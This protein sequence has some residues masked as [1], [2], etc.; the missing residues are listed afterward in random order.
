MSFC[1]Q[2]GMNLVNL[3]N[4]T[5]SANISLSVN[6]ALQL[7]NCSNN[8]WYSYGSDTGLVGNIGSLTGGIICSA[9][10]L[11]G[12]YCVSSSVTQ[13]ATVCVR[14]DQIDM[15]QKCSTDDINQRF[16]VQKSLFIRKTIYGTTLNVFYSRS[17]AQ[18]DSICSRTDS[19]IGTNY[20]NFNCTFYL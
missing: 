2:Y 4:S 1:S 7:K 12:L 10:P 9:V 13:A 8:F 6:Q 11:L 14:K 16:D 5:N 17:E 20:K 15:K 3:T 18:C 19:C